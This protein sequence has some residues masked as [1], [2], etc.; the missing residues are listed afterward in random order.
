MKK[1]ASPEELLSIDQQIAELQKKK[2]EIQ[3][4]DAASQAQPQVP[5]PATTTPLPA[6]APG[7]GLPSMAT[8]TNLI[9]VAHSI[10]EFFK[11]AGVD[12]SNEDARVLTTALMKIAMDDPNKIDE[13]LRVLDDSRSALSRALSATAAANP[14]E[15]KDDKADD[16]KEEKSEDKREKSED[17]KEEKSEDK[18]EKSDDKKPS[19][20]PKEEKKEE[21][22]EK[23]S[24]EAPKP[25][26]KKDEKSDDAEA[27]KAISIIEKLLEKEEKSGSGDPELVDLRRALEDIKKFLGDE[28]APMGAPGLEMKDPNKMD[29]LKTGP[30]VPLPPAASKPELGKPEEP[31]LGLEK[32]LHPITDA[33]PM[34]PKVV[35]PPKMDLAKELG[36]SPA[37]MA[38]GEKKAEF[39]LHDRVWTK[40]AGADYEIGD[41]P[42]RIVAIAEGK[43]IVDWGTDIPTEEIAENLVAAQPVGLEGQVFT[44]PVVSQE[45]QEVAEGLTAFTPTSQMVSKALSTISFADEMAKHVSA[46]SEKNGKDVTLTGDDF[47][48]E[49][50]PFEL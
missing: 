44:E 39:K 5:A 29:I 20:P 36:N 33:K 30:A 22:K 41:E 8:K 16:K 21:P 43:I 50:F 10:S 23:K 18:K 17:K 31:K 25:E 48:P 24:P 12:E 11:T 6:P 2:A 26:G 14:F 38:A 1:V 42:G 37:P 3:A 28:Q 4:R 19:F 32:N 7:Q 15:K 35:K 40:S 49:Q 27:K 45:E 47:K 34:G 13:I 9:S 46:L